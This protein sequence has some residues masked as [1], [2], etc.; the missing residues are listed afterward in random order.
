MQSNFKINCLIIC[1]LLSLTIGC[2]PFGN[3]TRP[4]VHIPP[5]LDSTTVVVSSRMADGNFVSSRHEKEA[6]ELTGF[7]K[8]NL[9]RVDEFW[10]YLELSVKKETA[11][12]EN[13]KQQFDREF[14][15]GAQALKYWKS[16]AKNEQAAK[17]A[18]EQCLIAQHHLEQALRIN[19]FDKNSRML[20]SV[21]YYYLQHHFGLQGNHAKAAEIL[22]RLIRIEMGEHEL[23]RLLGE[24]YLAAEKYDLALNS[25]N[26]ALN[27]M[28]KTSFDAP[29]DT[30]MIFHYTY[31][32]GDAYARGYDAANAVETLKI[33]E[34][35]ARSQQELSDVD[36]YLKW[37]QWDSGNIQASEIWDEVLALETSKEYPE[38]ADACKNLLPILT[39][40]NARISVMH[41]LAVIEFEVLGEK[42]IGIERMH[43]VYEALS[44]NGQQ[45]DIPG[46]RSY[47]D[48]YGAMLYRLGIDALERDDKKEALAYYNKAVSFEWD[49]V[50]KAY[51]EI[52]SLLWN[53]SEKAISYGEKALAYHDGLSEQQY[54]NLM[55]R[56]TRAHKSAGQ[57]DQARMYFNKWKQC[58]E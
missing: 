58:Q 6:N 8:Q 24:N 34:G 15:Q 48:T 16:L 32:M 20:L 33:A 27:V 2:A 3:K 1:L 31:A 14:T 39:T 23:F 45:L 17:A 41:K 54:C 57:Y 44:G 52:M 28:I 10:A 43:K 35:F 51:Y 19:P 53:N 37:I 30:T 21:T 11:I 13:E 56:M 40:T 47:L 29:P 9:A 49:Q 42:E 26:K 46:I 22:E 25:F 4:R 55:S 38:M 50:A 36:S 12:S 5:G 7:G 18:L